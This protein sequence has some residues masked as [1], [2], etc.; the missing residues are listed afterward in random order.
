MGRTQKN[1]ATEYHLGQLK[2]SEWRSA[3][4]G[5]GGGLLLR[6]ACSWPGVHAAG[7][8]CHH[9]LEPLFSWWADAESG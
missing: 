6:A 1:K 4:G 3:A 5:G 8:R 9:P 2:A 7:C